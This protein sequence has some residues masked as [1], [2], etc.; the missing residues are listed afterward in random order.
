M[1]PEEEKYFVASGMAVHGGSFVK[2][3]GNALSRAD[4]I[5]AQKIKDAFPEHWVKYLEIGKKFIESEQ[6][7]E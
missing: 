4:T 1:N 7:G 2:A 5:N 6:A 3:L